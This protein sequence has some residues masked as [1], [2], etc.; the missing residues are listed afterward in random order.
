MAK[1]AG[2]I[3][4]GYMAGKPK[5]TRQGLSKNTSL[6]ASARNGRRKRYRGQGH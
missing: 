6:A 4:T 1:S 2:L 5:C 3:K